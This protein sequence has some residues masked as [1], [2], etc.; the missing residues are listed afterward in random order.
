[1]LSGE[2]LLLRWLITSDPANTVHTPEIETVP[3]AL[4]IGSPKGL[5][6]V[7]LTPSA[8]VNRRL[9][10][11]LRRDLQK[12]PP[13][14][15]LGIRHEPPHLP[16]AS[17]RRA[18]L[19]RA[20]C[21]AVASPRSGIADEGD[22]P[23]LTVA[24][25][26][27]QWQG[28]IDARRQHGPQIPGYGTMTGSSPDAAE[29]GAGGTAA[30]A[31]AVTTGPSGALGASTPWRRWRCGTAAVS[32]DDAESVPCLGRYGVLWPVPGRI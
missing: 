30:G 17:A 18:S 11:D 9:R 10:A 27:T 12:G 25:R 21:S 8:A 14:S 28:F 32:G 2:T 26:A 15:T 16:S 22:D 31:S 7:W 5:R 1:M 24:D 20:P 23:H 29:V 13:N 3:V 4:R 6:G 19:A